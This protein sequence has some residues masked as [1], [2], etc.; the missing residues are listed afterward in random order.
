MLQ[1]R[2][3]LALFI[4]FVGSHV[5]RV[6]VVKLSNQTKR[7]N[8]SQHQSGKQEIYVSLKANYM[9]RNG[10]STTLEPPDGRQSGK[11]S[12]C[13]GGGQKQAPQLIRCLR[14]KYN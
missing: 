8:D 4:L 3:L 2:I 10:M 7:N 6:F 5:M 13:M 1:I 12:A 9:F 14:R 11:D